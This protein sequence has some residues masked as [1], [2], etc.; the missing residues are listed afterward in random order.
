MAVRGIL[1]PINP[2]LEK[3]GGAF[4]ITGIDQDCIDFL[5]DQHERCNECKEESSAVYE[6]I[7]AYAENAACAVTTAY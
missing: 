4:P 2:A 6:E 7:T 3:S 5:N 1:E